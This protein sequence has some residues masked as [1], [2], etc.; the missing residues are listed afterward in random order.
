MRLSP[1][2][3]QPKAKSGLFNGIWLNWEALSQAERVYATG[4]VLIPL[5]WIW[6]WSYLLLLLACGVL[7][8]EYRQKGRIELKPP[9]PLIIFLF[10]HSA[11]GIIVKILYGS[12]HP[13]VTFNT[14]DFTGTLN[15]FIAPAILIWYIISK[16]IRVRPQ[17]VAWAFSVLV[18]TMLLFWVVIF[19]GWR[20]AEFNPPRSIFA[21]LTGK[22]A[23]FVFGAGGINYLR[24][25][26]T[27]DISIAGFARYFFFFPTP[28][29][30]SVVLI[31]INLLALDIKNRL[32]KFLLLVPGIFL[33]LLS[34]TRS[35][36]VALTLVM[37][38]RFLL[39]T[40]KVWGKRFIFALI[41]IISF[42]TLCLPPVTNIILDTYNNSAKATA[43]YRGDST[44]VRSEIYKRT[45]KEI[46]NSS[47]IQ[48]VF[49]FVEEGE[50]VLPGYEPA[51][52]GSHSLYLGSLLYRRGIFGTAIFAGYWLSL[53]HYIYQ[54]RVGRPH[55]P[56]LFFLA[57]SLTF[58]VM[59]LEAVLMPMILVAVG[60]G[61]HKPKLN[62]RK[63]LTFNEVV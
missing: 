22:G 11:Y 20:E 19:F 43:E 13:H 31:F 59:S 25:Y 27:G 3:C 49:G 9:H 38:V 10:A 47:D 4:I 63:T 7:V 14:R 42:V 26:R 54:T 5:W 23:E 8:Y 46:Q 24:P 40:G 39:T 12:A 44:D 33:L 35:A 37:G 50:S 21:T 29:A 55:A 2:S 60:T 34:G 45:I 51:K 57:L 61:E 6:G 53:I 56:L 52:V 58:F 18:I 15:D 41:A 16:R 1:S 17:V 30:L 48:F 28:E 62:W 32:W 36:W